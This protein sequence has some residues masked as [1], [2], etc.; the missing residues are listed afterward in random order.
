MRDAVP[1]MKVPAGHEDGDNAADG[2][3]RVLPARQLLAESVYEAVK[4]QIMDLE[5]APGARINMDQLARTLEVSNTPL[6]EA[7]TRLES[8]GLVTRRSLQGYSV[9]PLPA[10]SDLEE[11]FALRL[12]LES[13]ATRTATEARHP[14]TLDKLRATIDDMQQLRTPSAPARAGEQYIRYRVL[15]GADAIFHDLI[16]EASGSKLLRHTLSGLHCHIPLYRV[17][18][19]VGAAP[20]GRETAD[21]HQAIIDAIAD[22][23]PRPAVAAMREHVERSRQRVVHA[24]LQAK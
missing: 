13:E 5:L 6:R 12:L 4:R 14:R 7:L 9:V 15:V 10:R 2:L 18:F 21:E 8:E 19:N 20:E 3:V 22:G 23:H 11:L 17:Y 1:K 16:A 24:Y